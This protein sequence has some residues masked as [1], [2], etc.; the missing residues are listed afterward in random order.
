VFDLKYFFQFPGGEAAGLG[1]IG[2]PALHRGQADAHPARQLFLGP[3][4]LH[5]HGADLSVVR[6][7]GLPS[8]YSAMSDDT[9]FKV[10]RPQAQGQ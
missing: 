3:A 2:F 6:I 10:T 8:I 4:F 7:H 5:A 9:A 1:A